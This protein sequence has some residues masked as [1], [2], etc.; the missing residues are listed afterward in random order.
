MGWYLK[1]ID[2]GNADMKQ[3]VL[4]LVDTFKK[5]CVRIVC[6]PAPEEGSEVASWL[7]ELREEVPCFH[8]A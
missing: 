3:Q 4:G 7:D 8:F 2:V 5:Q 1:N 6:D